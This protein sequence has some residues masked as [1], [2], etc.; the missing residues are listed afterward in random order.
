MAW[1][2]ALAAIGLV[3]FLFNSDIAHHIP[4][5]ELTIRQTMI[6]SAIGLVTGFAIH[7]FERIR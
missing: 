4:F 7:A 6:G 5:T 3:G 2:I 1:W